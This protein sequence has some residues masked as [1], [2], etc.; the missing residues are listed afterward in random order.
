MV[1]ASVCGFYCVPSKCRLVC[2]EVLEPRLTT[3]PIA[4][5]IYTAA[6]HGVVGFVRSYGKHLPAEGI[7][8]NAICPNVV[9]TSISTETFYSD[10][11]A[12]KL[13]VPMETVVQAFERCLDADIS[14]ETLEIETRSGITHRSAPEPF[15]QDAADTL[16]LLH[17]RGSPLHAQEQVDN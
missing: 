12:R 3:V 13:L 15:D 10:M 7:S 17:V 6:K 8:L 11:Q 1:T 16:A 4:L 5:P 2:I 9:R 14:G